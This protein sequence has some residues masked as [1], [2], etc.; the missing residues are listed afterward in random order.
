MSIYVNTWARFEERLRDKY[1]NEDTQKM[2][3]REFFLLDGAT[4]K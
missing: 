3:K 4:T 1:F 2:S